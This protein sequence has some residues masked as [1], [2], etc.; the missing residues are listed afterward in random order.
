M[1]VSI[2]LGLKGLTRSRDGSLTV[3]RQ[4]AGHI[5]TQAQLRIVQEDWCPGGIAAIRR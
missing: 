1:C 3:T 2:A 4:R 5:D